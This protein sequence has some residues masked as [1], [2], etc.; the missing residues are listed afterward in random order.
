MGSD[1]DAMMVTHVGAGVMRKRLACAL[2]V[3]PTLAV[4]TLWCA[5]IGA[6][7][8]SI[9]P[10]ASDSTSPTATITVSPTVG[11]FLY[12]SDFA[13][14]KVA[15]F[16]RNLTA[17]T[18]ALTLIGS[19]AAGSV[20][21]PIGVANGPSAKFLYVANA[22]DGNV[23]EFA[24]NGTTG[25]LTAVDGSPVA[26]GKSPQWIAV[27]P[28]AQFA[29][30]ANLGDATISQYAVDTTTGA[31]TANGAA[32][33]SPLL[34]S[35]TAAV[36][37]NNWLYVTD[38]TNGTIV[39]FP[40]GSTTGTLLPGT[41]T[42]PGV[43]ATPG[44]VVMDPLGNFVYVSDQ[45]SGVVYFLTVGTGILTPGALPYPSSDAGEAGLAIS[46]TTL[47]NEFLF[48]ANQM[49]I[50]PSI[51]VFFVNAGGTLT[52]T[53]AFPDASLSLPTGLAVDPTGAF[54]Y[55]ANQGNGTISTFTI[56]PTAGTLGTGVAVSTGSTTSSPLY[57]AIGD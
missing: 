48:V 27:T 19:V 2:R 24:I 29:F 36:A 44:A 16:T 14:G 46:P 17:G 12:S 32:F 15:E 37:S 28:N 13:A 33:S 38:A 31:L 21:G 57:L 20:K 1:V 53:A 47:G 10:L 41:P 6:C 8:R 30:V 34:A 9:Y 22:A 5:F 7:G 43:G 4:L 51:S 25:K 52:F 42:A 11:N 56:D 3:L 18:G 50:P 26:A 54:L 23:R 39:S 35:P 45:K 49:S 55:A 40:I